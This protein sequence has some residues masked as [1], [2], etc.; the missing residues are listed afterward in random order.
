MFNQLKPAIRNKPIII[1]DRASN[2]VIQ[3]RIVDQTQHRYR[4]EVGHIVV[5]IRKEDVVLFKDSDKTFRTLI[6]LQTDLDHAQLSIDTFCSDN[7]V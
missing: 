6:K 7:R 5:G 3:T 4:I 2:R 1:Y